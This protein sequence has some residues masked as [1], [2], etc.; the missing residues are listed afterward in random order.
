MG[1]VRELWRAEDAAR[2]LNVRTGTV[3]EWAA[4][5]ILPHVRILA[6]TRRA[7]VRFR[8]AELEEFVRSRTT[9]GTAGS[10]QQHER[11]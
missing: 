5:G 10:A 8:K 1:E 11:R 9:T 2:F 7:V 6:G 4:K 3:Y